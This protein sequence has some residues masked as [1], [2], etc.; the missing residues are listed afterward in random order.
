MNGSRT[1]TAEAWRQ[2]LTLAEGV[3]DLSSRLPSS[4]A[5]VPLAH[6][7]FFDGDVV[8][9]EYGWSLVASLAK[10][11]NDPVVNLL[12]IDPDADFFLEETGEYGG[13]SC[14]S[15]SDSDGY[16]AG[17]FGETRRSV[18]GQIG[19]AAEIVVVFGTR[20]RWGIWVERGVAGLIVSANPSALGPWELENGPFLTADDALEGFLGVNFGGS[21]DSEFAVSLLHNYRTFRHEP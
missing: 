2:Q 14:Q 19:Y 16:V 3:F 21:P 6:A 20:G 7:P 15:G 10:V 9:G 4:V 17:L 8:F 13:F 1:R 18:V 12:V 5:R 11:H